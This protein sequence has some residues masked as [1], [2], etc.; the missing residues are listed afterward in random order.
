MNSDSVIGLLSWWDGVELWL[1]GRGFIL[2]TIIVMP[3]V[4]VLAYAMAVAGDKILFVLFSVT[5][6]L[7]RLYQATRRR[8]IESPVI[9]V[10]PAD[11]P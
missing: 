7:G 8:P 9:A 11:L 5:N 6:R 4:L 1:S 3:V 10:V 2:Q